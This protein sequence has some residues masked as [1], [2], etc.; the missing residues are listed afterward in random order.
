MEGLCDGMY[1]LNAG[2][3]VAVLS[4]RLFSMP[5]ILF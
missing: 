4:G 1:V 5:F 3:K 2:V